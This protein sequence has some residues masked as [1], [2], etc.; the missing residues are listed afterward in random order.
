MSTDNDKSPQKDP[1]QQNSK[2]DDFQPDEYSFHMV[3]PPEKY[4]RIAKDKL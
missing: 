1:E 3:F 4:I 2:Q